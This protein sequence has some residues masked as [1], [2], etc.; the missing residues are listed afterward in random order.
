MATYNSTPDMLGVV[1][2]IVT[3]RV[4]TVVSDL[5][6]VPNHL[7]RKLKRIAELHITFSKGVYQHTEEDESAL[8]EVAAWLWQM[9]Q[10]KHP[11]SKSSCPQLDPSCLRQNEG[12]QDIIPGQEH[13]GKREP[14]ELYAF[15]IYSTREM[16]R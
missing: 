5:T 4:K 2:E 12:L 3:R 15:V 11:T 13:L 1:G 14:G 8:R 16:A 10:I 6:Q 9:W 7:N